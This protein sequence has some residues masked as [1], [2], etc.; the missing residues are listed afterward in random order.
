M[1]GPAFRSDLR[2]ARKAQHADHLPRHQDGFDGTRAVRGQF[3]LFSYG[4]AH[5]RDHGLPDDLS[6]RRN[7]RAPSQAENYLPRDRRLADAVVDLADGR[8]FRKAAASRPMAKAKTV[9]DFQ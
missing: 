8:T 5:D 3:L 6:L 7:P 1:D 9:R 4:R 2:R